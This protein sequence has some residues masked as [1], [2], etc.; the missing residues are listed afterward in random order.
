MDKILNIDSFIKESENLI[1]NKGKREVIKTE[2]KTIQNESFVLIKS[3]I[4][5]YFNE[6]LNQIS[7]NKEISQSDFNSL[8]FGSKYNLQRKIM[9]SFCDIF[10]QKKNDF[11]N[12]YI[13]IELDKEFLL[14]NDLEF[15]TK[16]L[17]KRNKIVIYIN[18]L[19]MGL[20]KFSKNSKFINPITG[21]YKSLVDKFQQKITRKFPLCI[22]K[23]DQ[24][25]NLSV[26]TTLFM[27]MLFLE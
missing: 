21:E 16:G 19:E 22:K 20:I 8:S 1:L 26:E 18:T 12:N 11:L 24:M 14:K 7:I 4:D 10:K 6:K 3:Y 27:G 17:L 5:E 9:D 15:L 13:F 23:D 2:T 25:I